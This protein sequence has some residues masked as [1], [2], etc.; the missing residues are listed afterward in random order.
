MVAVFACFL[1]FDTTS[2][3]SEGRG[4]KTRWWVMGTGMAPVARRS[5]RGRTLVL[6]GPATTPPGSIPLLFFASAF[7]HDAN[8]VH[9]RRRGCSGLL[10]HRCMYVC[11]S[12]SSLLC[13][14]D[15]PCSHSPLLLGCCPLSSVMLPTPLHCA[16]PSMSP[17]TIQHNTTHHNKPQHTTPHTPEKCRITLH[18]LALH[19]R[20]MSLTCEVGLFLPLQP[21]IGVRPSWR[22][23]TEPSERHLPHRNPECC[24]AAQSRV[25]FC[26]VAPARCKAPAPV[27]KS[28]TA[29]PSPSIVVRSNCFLP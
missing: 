28:I 15:Q 7:H 27:A 22:A 4:V 26:Q 18:Q 5:A 11:P 10:F 14:N 16:T 12:L 20:H 23:T 21:R 13:Q 6:S 24:H 3:G 25:S 17:T 1:L 29:V 2:P 9:H 8:T 19:L